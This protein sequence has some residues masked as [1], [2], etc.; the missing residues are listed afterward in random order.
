MDEDVAKGDFICEYKYSNSYPQKERQA[1]EREYE[2]NGE[3]CY[4]LEVAADVP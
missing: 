1:M 3:G 2:L 4:V